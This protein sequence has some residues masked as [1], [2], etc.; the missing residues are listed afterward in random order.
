[1]KNL[2]PKIKDIVSKIGDKNMHIIYSFLIV[3][4]IGLINIIAGVVIACIIGLAKGIYDQFKQSGY[5]NGFESSNLYYDTI[6][7]IIALVVLIILS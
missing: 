3:F 7:I 1:M 6:G 4:L 5:F 2:L